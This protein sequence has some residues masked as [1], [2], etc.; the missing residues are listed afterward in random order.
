MSGE[1]QAS[2]NRIR[3]DADGLRVFATEVLAKLGVPSEDAAM[4][5]DV[6]VYADLRGVETH[7]MSNNN[8]GRIYVRDIQSGKI[9]PD[10]PLEVVR[11]TPVTALLDANLGL[12]L[13]AGVRA[14]NMAIEKARESFIGMVAVKNSHHFGA[15]QYF[16][17][18]AVPHGMIGISSTNSNPIVLPTGGRQPVYG[19]NPISV[20]APSGSEPD[21]CLDVGTSAMVFQKLILTTRLGA[22]IPL[23]V[24][25]DDEGV[26][27]S[28][29]SEAVE[30]RKLLPLGSTPELGSHKGYG[31]GML[32][33]VLCGILPGHGASIQL[34]AYESYGSVGHFFCAIRVDAF[35][36]LEE[37]RGQMDDMFDRVHRTEPVAG[38]ERVLVAGDPEAAKEEERRRLGVPL[39]PA[40]VE[41]LRELGEDVG[42][43]WGLTG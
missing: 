7:G 19:T 12:G 24:A 13:S 1:G 6:L 5:A 9:K 3:V 31:L 32:V 36:P 4:A 11:E 30:A 33:D 15:A 21:F 41:E 26:P 8:L 40:V 43:A 17:M 37:F 25:A 39:L 10:A 14:M 27:T 34:D 35:R 18:M 28:S 20:G 42:V 38:V 16:S 23:G 22:E 29:A 2:E